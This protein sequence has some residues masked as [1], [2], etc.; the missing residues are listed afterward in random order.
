MTSLDP[1]APVPFRVL[2][3]DRETADTFTLELAPDEGG[4]PFGFRPGQFNML[5]VFGKGEAPISISGD[6]GRRDRLVHTTRVVGAVTAGMGALKRGDVLGVRGPFGTAWPVDETA[7]SDVIFIAGGIGLAPL[8]PAILH[9]LANRSRYGR[10][11]LLYG[12]RTPEDVLYRRDL[13]T[14]RAELDMDVYVTVDR[15]SRDWHG[16]VGVVTALVP[17]I[18]F[19]RD[20]CVAMLCGPEVMMR[21]AVLELLKR[22]IPASMVHLSMERNMKCAVG[23]CGHCQVGPHFVCK[24]GPVFR[25]DELA[26]LLKIR[27]V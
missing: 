6:P 9:V 5:Y 2:R 27:E 1:M 3:T 7:G 4:P 12:A 10:V 20:N 11:A 8:R 24:D 19:D 26:R 17:R 15:A 14:W 23:F 25:Y 22:G 16:D 21:F 18:P 13:R